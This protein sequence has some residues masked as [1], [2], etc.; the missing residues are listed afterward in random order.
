MPI[1]DPR[2]RFFFLSLTLMID[3]FI[4][5]FICIIFA[6]Y[7]LCLSCF[8]AFSSQPCGQLLG[9]GCPLDPLVCYV[10]LCFCHF[11]MWW[12]GSGVVLDCIDS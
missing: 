3:S 1:G 8:L 4:L 6:I 9:N 10:L 12:P 11:P 5:A 2:E 7:A